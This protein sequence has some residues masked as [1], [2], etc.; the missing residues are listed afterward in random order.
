MSDVAPDAA[1]WGA[2]FVAW[3]ERHGLSLT[4]AANLLGCSRKSVKEWS[5]RRVPEMYPALR[6]AMAAVDANPSLAKDANP[7]QRR[8]EPGEMGYSKRSLAA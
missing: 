4:G 6:L 8:R 2:A 7:T 3:R 5:G 1:E